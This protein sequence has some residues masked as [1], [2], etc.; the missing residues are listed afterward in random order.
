[1]KE[2]TKKLDFLATVLDESERYVE[3]HVVRT[4]VKPYIRDLNL[5]ESG[6]L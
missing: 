3:A 2:K 6:K 5:V 4:I 1:M